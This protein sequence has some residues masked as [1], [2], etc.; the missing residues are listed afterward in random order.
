MNILLSVIIPIYNGAPFLDDCIASITR[1]HVEHLEIILVDDGSTDSSPE[2]CDT[3]A[4]A[5]PRIKVIHQDNQGQSSA[6]NSALDICQGKYI[7]FADVDDV[8]LENTYLPNLEILEQDDSLTA[9]QFPYIY[10]Y[11]SSSPRKG[12]GKQPLWEGEEDILAA[13]MSPLAN[14]AVWN[15]NFRRTVFDQLRFPVGQKFEDTYIIP[16]LARIMPRMYSSGLGAYGYNLQENSTMSS[17]MTLEKLQDRVLANERIVHA[18]TAYPSLFASPAFGIYYHCCALL[19]IG[20]TKRS[21]NAS[22]LTP[23]YQAALDEFKTVPLPTLLSIWHT[24]LPTKEKLRLLLI[25]VTGISFY[26][27]HL[28]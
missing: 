17:E 10:P 9:V 4:Q 2:L 27:S 16:D 3:L 18:A 25:R 1:Q 11:N 12:A 23:S 28:A 19:S 20:I 15:K 7:T 26:L 24:K 13:F 14:H 6:R 21:R 22:A 5:D 8:I